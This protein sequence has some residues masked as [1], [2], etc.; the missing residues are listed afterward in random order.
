[1]FALGWLTLFSVNDR[2][3]DFRMRHV[4]KSIKIDRH[5]TQNRSIKFSAP[6]IEGSAVFKV[7]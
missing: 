4:D 7:K 6:S 1:L 3:S 2:Y 5:Q